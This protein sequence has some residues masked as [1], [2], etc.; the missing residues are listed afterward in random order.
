MSARTTELVGIYH[1]PQHQKPN[2]L[3]KDSTFMANQVSILR[4][5]LITVKMFGIKAI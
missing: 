4:V 3:E 5:I 1:S 2:G